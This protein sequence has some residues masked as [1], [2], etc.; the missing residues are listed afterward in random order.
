QRAVE[1][2]VRKTDGGIQELTGH[3]R[4]RLVFVKVA[5]AKALIELVQEIVGI[6]TM[7]VVREKAHRGLARAGQVQDIE[8]WA[9]F[10]RSTKLIEAVTVACL[11]LAS[12]LG[13]Q[14]QQ[15]WQGYSKPGRWSRVAAS[16]RKRR[17]VAGLRPGQ[18]RCCP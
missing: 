11:Q 1:F 18:C 15:P 13:P 14:L 5:V 6:K 7:A 4:V 17:R 12:A 9:I 8:S 2:A 16:E 10:K 3:H